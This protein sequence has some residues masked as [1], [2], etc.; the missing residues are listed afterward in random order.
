M[1]IEKPA[2]SLGCGEVLRTLQSYLDGVLDDVTA[3]RVARH[4]PGCRR[5]DREAGIYRAIKNA[6]AERRGT[7]PEAIQR[8]R[9]FARCLLD[10]PEMN[11]MSHT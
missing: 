11:T 9:N 2:G 8:L 5:C 3:E 1:R 4:L 7:S 10:E 6:L